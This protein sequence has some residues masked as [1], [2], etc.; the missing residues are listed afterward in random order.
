MIAREKENDAK[1]VQMIACLAGAAFAAPAMA[2]LTVYTDRAAWEAAVGANPIFVEDFNNLATGE[3]ADG[4]TLD[5]GII[6][7]T[8][9]GSPN[10]ADGALAISPGDQFGNFDGTNHLDGETGIM[11]GESVDFGFNGSSVF[12]F[13]ADWV[14]PF[15]GDGI[16]LEVG[17]ELILLDSIAGLDAGFIGFVSDSATFSTISVV[18]TPEDITFQELWQADNVSYAV[19]APSALA[20]LGLGGMVAG[21]RRR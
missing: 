11:P 9:D 19:P 12:A 8:R 6:Q 17:N 3:I 1:N 10:G 18:G 15:S 5:T 16:A 13:G 7:I 21:R 2:Q 14:S 20:L 4:A